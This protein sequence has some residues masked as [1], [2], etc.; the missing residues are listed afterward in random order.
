MGL[1]KSINWI[2]TDKCNAKCIHCD[3]WK[4]GS[5]SSVYLPDV[6]KVL[7]DRL[8][9]DS[10]REYGQ[11]FDISLCGGEPFLLE[12]LQEIVNTIE[13]RLP[14]SFKA[15]TTNGL[16]TNSIL[17]FVNENRGLNFKLNISIDG[18]GGIH[19]RIRGIKGAFNK[20]TDTILKIRKINPRQK[21]E[22]KF[23]SVVVLVPTFPTD[24]VVLF[25]DP[26]E[27][28]NSPEL[29]LYISQ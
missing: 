14:G 2:I 7:N 3:I 28:K 21:V 4:S 27:Q 24:R 18:L 22:L 9:L 1:I 25:P 11:N 29:P 26:D 13:N 10:Y 12:N 17:K 16:C 19:D 20:T 6:K 23:T 15:I 8:I 5:R